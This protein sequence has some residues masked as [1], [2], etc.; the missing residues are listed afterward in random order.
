MSKALRVKYLE[1][2]VHRLKVKYNDLLDNFIALREA[3]E[4]A[5]YDVL[6]NGQ[7]KSIYDDSQQKDNKLS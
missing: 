1:E 7:V 5:G 6:V 3:I 2:E 4:D